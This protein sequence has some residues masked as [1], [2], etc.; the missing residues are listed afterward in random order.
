M[1]DTQ[2]AVAE[3]VHDLNKKIEILSNGMNY[4]SCL[5]RIEIDAMNS[6]NVI[7][8]SRL[9]SNYQKEISNLKQKIDNLV[10]DCK[11]D[12]EFRYT[13][14]NVLNR[15]FPLLRGVSR[16]PEYIDYYVC[17]SC[18]KS[19]WQERAK[20]GESGDSDGV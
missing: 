17:R 5:I 16:T 11:H 7:M 6:Q 12:F 20:C 2:P 13:E 10:Q 19:M 15:K 1:S 9:H 3:S 4:C 8:I 14:K 18:R